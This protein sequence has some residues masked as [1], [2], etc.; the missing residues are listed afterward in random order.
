METIK[1]FALEFSAIIVMVLV[2][3]ALGKLFEH[4]FKRKMGE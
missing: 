1:E 3:A 4:F 2:V